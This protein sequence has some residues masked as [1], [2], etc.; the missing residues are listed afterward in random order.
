MIQEQRKKILNYLADKDRFREMVFD[1]AIRSDDRYWYFGEDR[2]PV[3]KDDGSCASINER[4]IDPLL[5]NWLVDALPDTTEIPVDDD[6]EGDD[7]STLAG[8]AKLAPA[9][10]GEVFVNSCDEDGKWTTSWQTVDYS[11]H[12][13]CV[14]I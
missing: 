8:R 4:L 9:G 3:S 2:L 5:F 13:S 7:L 12:S 10:P 1:K 14:T 6:S 11:I